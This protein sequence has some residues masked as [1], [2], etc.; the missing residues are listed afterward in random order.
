[1]SIILPG[2]DPSNKKCRNALQQK[3]NQG[4]S[5]ASNVQWQY[6]FEPLKK[7]TL[8]IFG[9]LALA[10]STWS[11]RNEAL[12]KMNEEAMKQEEETARKEYLMKGLEK[13]KQKTIAEASRVKMQPELNQKR[14]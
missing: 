4:K 1:M 12:M 6:N 5:G 11:I 8:I 3:I 2:N 13:I 7:W 9:A 10:M 14:F